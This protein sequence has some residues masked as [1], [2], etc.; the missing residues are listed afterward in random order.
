MC[1][2]GRW[3]PMRHA[4]G[5]EVAAH[6][7]AD[8]KAVPRRVGEMPRARAR[9]A[10]VRKVVDAELAVAVAPL[11]HPS[12]DADDVGREPRRALH[13]HARRVEGVV[14]ERLGR[15]V[16]RPE[17]LARRGAAREPVRDRDEEGGREATWHD[18]GV[19]GKHVVG[20]LATLVRGREE[21]GRS[22]RAAVWQHGRQE[23]RV[24]ARAQDERKRRVARRLYLQHA[25][26]AGAQRGELAR[27]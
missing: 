15:A 8:A 20:R 25:I 23:G 21:H 27:E 4:I 18:G 14:D 24:G 12:V 6:E 3:R 7:R 5:G 22:G 17:A 11:G 19:V 26:V 13:A 1:G 10:K 2:S 9:A 16:I